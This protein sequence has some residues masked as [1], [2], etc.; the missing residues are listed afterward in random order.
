MVRHSHLRSSSRL[1]SYC[2]KMLSPVVMGLLRECVCVCV[3]VCERERER[4]REDWPATVGRVRRNTTTGRR[5]RVVH[6]ARWAAAPGCVSDKERKHIRTQWNT[7]Y[8][9]VRLAV[10]RQ[11]LEFIQRHTL[12]PVPSSMKDC[13]SERG[14]VSVSAS[15]R[16]NV[17]T[18]TG[19]S[20][21]SR[22]TSSGWS[23]WVVL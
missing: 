19:R 14:R 13:A 1:M 18:G 22:S 12:Q 4:E 7:I 5:R 8:Q 9:L 16:V 20:N 15:A 11:P 10:E 3:C 21:T 17:C 2:S 6:P 23:L